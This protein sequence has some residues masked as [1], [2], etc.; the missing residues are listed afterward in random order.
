MFDE[1]SAAN[2]GP[3]LGA[4]GQDSPAELVWELLKHRIK[5]PRPVAG[6]LAR[7]LLLDKLRAAARPGGILHLEAPAGYAKT[8]TACAAFASTEQGAEADRTRWLTLN[9]H[10][11]DPFRFLGLLRL[12]LGDAPEHTRFQADHRQG[13]ALDALAMLLQEFAAATAEG[14][15]ADRILVLDNIDWLQHGALVE[16]LEFLLAELPDT[17]ALV[18]I[19]RKPLPFSTH[20]FEL[21]QRYVRIGSQ[22][23]EFSRTET[24]ALFAPDL[25]A[26]LLTQVAIENLYSQ[27]EGWPTPLALY[28][29][30]LV[31]RQVHR[32]ALHEATSV[33]RF[34]YDCVFALLTPAQRQSLQIMAELEYLSDE[35]FAAV[36]D[37]PADTALGPSAA[38]ARGLPLRTAAG[39]GRWYRFNPLVRAWLGLLAPAGREQRAALAS[40][41]LEQQGMFTEALQYALIS[42]QVARAIRVASEGSESLLLSQDTASLLR[43]RQSLPAGLIQRSPRLRIVY[44][45]VHAL[46]GQFTEARALL[47]GL[48]P[49]EQASLEDRL[50]ALRAFINRMEGR[51]DEALTEASRA[52]EFTELSTHARLISLLV[53]SSV[54]CVQGRFQEAR[55]DSRSASK[56]ARQS[57]DLGSE[58]LAVYTHARIELGKGALRYAEQLL[59][60]GLDTL[61]SDSQRPLRAGEIRL[62]LNLVLVLWHQGRIDEADTLLVKV[63]RHAEQ[64]RDVS[65]LMALALRVLISKSRG[66]LED[67]FS[68]I[69]HAERTMHAWHVDDAFHVPVLEALKTSCW[70]QLGYSESVRQA[71]IT[72]KPYS[73]NHYVPE[74]FPMLPGMLDT[75]E[76]RQSL[77]TDQLELAASQLAGLRVVEDQP[78]GLALHLG[79]LEVALTGRQ[80][81]KSKAQALLVQ[82]I[83]EAETEHYL[84][85]FVELREELAEVMAPALATMPASGFTDQLRTFYNLSTAADGAAPL[86]EPI[87]ERELGVLELIAMGLSNQDIADQLHISLH[88]VKTHARRINAKLEV[89]SR[90]QAIVRARELGILPG[91]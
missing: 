65:L 60:T 63:I 4:L 56:L 82:Q 48:T 22:E 7:P 49:A 10:D 13:R 78:A 12:A 84:S 87:S 74:L 2:D 83:R 80:G 38:V 35:L 77:A 37:A 51:V 6:F 36:V 11:N 41:W 54:L 18:L 32:K 47:A 19:S 44:G 71:L 15:L 75:L 58:V 8:Q 1:K 70:L 79:L 59:R 14:E 62:Q 16:L 20:R 90:T 67:A 53:K 69:G 29:Q 26:N 25:Q 64:N 61:I 24:A 34:L 57:G 45:W 23:L 43:L 52:L 39:R 42:G 46:G 21:E 88:T 17:L 72:L 9:E 91:F 30:E 33:D 73:D 27:T 76:I 55:N 89:R 81:A 31:A 3:A 28:R 66:D 68:W 5:A 85:P 40:E 50:C 86:A